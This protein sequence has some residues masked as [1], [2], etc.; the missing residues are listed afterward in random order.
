MSTGTVSEYIVHPF[1]NSNHSQVC[2]HST[3]QSDNWSHNSPG[4]AKTWKQKRNDGGK[5][6][7]E[8]QSRMQN[9][10]NAQMNNIMSR[11]VDWKVWTVKKN[12][13]AQSLDYNLTQ[14]RPIT[15][16]PHPPHYFQTQYTQYTCWNI[17][18]LVQNHFVTI[19]ADTN[20][21]KSDSICFFEAC[22]W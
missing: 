9:A 4:A 3:L 13:M 16:H 10:M 20:P 18:D 5:Q 15:T 22:K 19:Y 21:D 7:V 8:T 14:T 6:W 1:I 12:E 2:K 17:R 11:F